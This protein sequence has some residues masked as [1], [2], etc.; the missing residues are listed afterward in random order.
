MKHENKIS[1]PVALLRHLYWDARRNA[2][3]YLMPT[4]RRQSPLDVTTRYVSR[5]V[6]FRPEGFFV[7]LVA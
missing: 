3:T 7:V 6:E 2:Y 5:P 4:Q 1:I